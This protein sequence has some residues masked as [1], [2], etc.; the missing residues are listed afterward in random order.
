MKIFKISSPGSS[1]SLMKM[2]TEEGTPVASITIGERGRGRNER[3]I[4]IIGE[5]PEVRAKKTDEGGVVLVRGNWDESDGRCLT[6]INTCGAYLRYKHYGIEEAE[7]V[8]TIASGNFAFGSAGRV[9]SGEEILAIC[10]PGATFRLDSKYA[11]HWYMWD[12]KEWRMESPEERNAR[13][14][15]AKVEQG[16]GEWL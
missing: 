5:G 3:I 11:S 15:L 7:G 14:A 4:P 1:P 6:V 10:S 9:G 16:G 8:Q 2:E 12:G 13:L